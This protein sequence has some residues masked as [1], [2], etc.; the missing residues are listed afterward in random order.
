MP[1]PTTGQVTERPWANRK[2]ITFGARLYAYGRRHRLVFG[3]NKQGWN[4]TRA[5][6]ELESI[7]QQVIRGTWVPPETKTSTVQSDAERPDGR[8][9]FGP[10]ARKVIDAKQSHGLD[11]DTIADLEWKLGYLL[12]YFGRMELADI[13]VARVDGFRDDL[14]GRARVIREAA[15]RG[16][17]LMETVDRREGKRYERR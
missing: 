5:E 12:G 16:K 3:T 14:A 1:W 6:I 10:F 7:Q 13:D 4:R 9:P 11:A 15:A 17:P 2:T 8:Q